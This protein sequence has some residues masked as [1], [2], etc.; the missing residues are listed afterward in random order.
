MFSLTISDL[1]LYFDVEVPQ[2]SNE[3][4]SLPF[5]VLAVVYVIL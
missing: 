1:V 3:E 4:P 5:F 2:A